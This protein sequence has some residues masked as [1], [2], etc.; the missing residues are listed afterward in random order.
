VARAVASQPQPLGFK[1]DVFPRDRIATAEQ[2]LVRMLLGGKALVTVRELSTFTISEEAQRATIDLQGSK[3]GV[4]AAR[5][6]FR[7]GER[8]EIRTP[9]TSRPSAARC[10]SP[11]GCRT[12]TRGSLPSAAAPPRSARAPARPPA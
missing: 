9:N 2:S 8:L 6:L 11:S 4:A 5:P 3:I 10:S 7:P 12:A 1:D